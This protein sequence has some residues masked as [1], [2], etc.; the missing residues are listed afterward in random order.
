MMAPTRLLKKTTKETKEFVGFTPSGRGVKVTTGRVD[1]TF[2]SKGDGES[3][4]NRFD[5]AESIEVLWDQSDD[6]NLAELPVHNHQL[7]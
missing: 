1:E 2:G 3:S 6:P 4:T 7:T 5:K